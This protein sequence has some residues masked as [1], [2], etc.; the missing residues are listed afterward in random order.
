MCLAVNNKDKIM[1][2]GAG[3]REVWFDAT[4]HKLYYRHN[5]M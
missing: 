4:I 1:K 2:L 5:I 3:A